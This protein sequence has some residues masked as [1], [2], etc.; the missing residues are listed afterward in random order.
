MQSVGVWAFC[1][2]HINGQAILFNFEAFSMKNIGQKIVVL[3]TVA[4]A[5]AAPAAF[6]ALDAG[7]STGLDT[8]ETDSLALQALVWP[9][10]ITVTGG[11]VMFKIFKRGANKV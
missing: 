5:V 1:F 3:L 8:I 6:A 2:T 10:V 9:V 4:L 7:I 11:F